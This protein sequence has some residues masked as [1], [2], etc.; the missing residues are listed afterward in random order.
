VSVLSKKG[1]DPLVRLGL[2]ARLG[3]TA[4][5]LLPTETLD[6]E[7]VVLIC[8]SDASHRG[9]LQKREGVGDLGGFQQETKGEEEAKRAGC[10]YTRFILVIY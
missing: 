1:R 8:P 6:D 7:R 4:L 9:S 10:F 5:I 2:P 3:L